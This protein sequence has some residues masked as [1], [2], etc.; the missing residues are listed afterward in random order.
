LQHILPFSSERK[1][2]ST[3]QTD[4]QKQGRLLVFTKGG[5]GRNFKRCSQ[6]L[7][8]EETRPLSDERRKVIAAVN[9][10][11]AGQALRTLGI[12]YRSLAADALKTDKVDDQV[13]QDLVYAG[14]IGMIDPPRPEPKKRL[15][16]PRA[17]EYVQ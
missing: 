4:A 16:V 2:M 8:G 11:L 9:E 14:V 13:E 17:P 3:V 7:S 12:A 5:A 6:E 10:E 15:R 1:L